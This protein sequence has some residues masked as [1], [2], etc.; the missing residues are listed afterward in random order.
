MSE[1]KV[2][3]RYAKSLI[4]LAQEQGSLETVKGDMAQFIAV[5]RASKELQAVLKNPIIKQDKK[6]KIL[7]ALFEAKIHP[8]ITAFFHIMVRKGRAG[9]LYA[10]AQEFIREYNEVKGIVK[11]TVASAVA[12]SPEHLDI[13][14]KIIASE[15]NAKIILKNK[16]DATLIG[17]F[18]ITVGDKQIDA[19]IAGKLHKLERHFKSQVV[20]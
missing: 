17:G 19:S 13:L 5:L 1:F 20:N 6:S 12:F 11:A 8:S 10:T 16:V 7:D 3:S 14:E 2:A 9:I 4:D 18:I 15:I